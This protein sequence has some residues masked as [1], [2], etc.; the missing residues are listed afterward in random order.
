MIAFV[1]AGTASGV[2]KTTVALALMAA[3]RERGYVVQP[4]KCGP[5]FLDPGHHS[6]ICGRVARNLDTW[7]LDGEANR[8]IFD[9]A[10][11]DADVAIV[12]GMMGLYDGV[13][14]VLG[15]YSHG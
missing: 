8:A 14:G 10:T 6:A 9:S 1:V 4:F 2:G 3:F 12:E 11:R 13:S 15:G 7:M 5:D